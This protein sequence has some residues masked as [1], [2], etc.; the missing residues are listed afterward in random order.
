MSKITIMESDEP[1]FTVEFKHPDR[2]IEIREFFPVVEDESEEGESFLD[3]LL[4]AWDKFDPAH[5]WHE[6]ECHYTWASTFC[7]EMNKPIL[8]FVGSYY[9]LKAE[10]ETNRQK[11][12]QQLEEE[13]APEITAEDLHDYMYGI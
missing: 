5:Y 2:G 9:E 6:V 3:I 10:C 8:L 13:W 1:K 11:R 4:A 12:L 7:P